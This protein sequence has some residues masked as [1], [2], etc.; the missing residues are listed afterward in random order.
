MKVSSAIA[1]ILLAGT[2][3]VAGGAWSPDLAFQLRRVTEVQVSPDGTR[4]AF[5]VASA[6][7]DAEKSEWVSQVH[8]ARADGSGSFQ[9]TRAEKSSTAPRWP[10][11]ARGSLSSPRGGR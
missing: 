4:A 11:M 5:V 8:I 9:L 2:P 7:M 3:V 6:M 1:L 10:L